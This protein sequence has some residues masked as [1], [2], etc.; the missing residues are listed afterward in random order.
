MEMKAKGGTTR[1]VMAA[2]DKGGENECRKKSRNEALLVGIALSILVLVS[3]RGVTGNDFINYD[4]PAYVTENR[5]VQRGLSVTELSWALTAS[6]AGNWHPLTWVSLMV[7]R[8]LFGMNAAGYHGTNVILHLASGLLLFVV[9]GRMTGRLWCSGL[10]SAF[11]LVHPLHVESVAWIAERKDVLSGLFWMLSIWAYV[12]YVEH[13]GYIRYGWVVLFFVLGFLSKPMVVTLP[14]VLLLL[15]WWP[16]RRTDERSILSLLGEKIPLVVLS[17]AGSIVTFFV[18]SEGGAVDSFQSLPLAGRFVNS[19][20]SYASYLVKMLFPLDLSAFY[21]RPVAWSIPE[22][23]LSLSLIFLISFFVLMRVRR[24][25]YLG[26]GWLWYLGMLVPVIGFVQV[27]AQ[28]MADRYTYLPLIGVFIMAVWGLDDLLKAIPAG[29]WVGGAAAGATLLVL[30]VMTQIQV[31]YWKDSGALFTHALRV[32]DN[33][34]VAHNNLGRASADQGNYREA[35]DQ[36][37][38]AIRISPYYMAAYNNLGI[39]LMKTGRLPEAMDSFTMALKIKPGDGYVHFNRGEVF[40]LRS[41]WDEAITEYR[42]ALQE[43]PY[44]PALRNNLGAALVKQGRLDDAVLQ[45]RTALRLDP[46]HAGAHA[47][48]GMLLMGRGQDEEAIGHFRE[49][50]RHRPEYA[51]A[52]YQLA[53]ALKKQGRT[54]ESVYH[55]REARRIK[56][57]IENAQ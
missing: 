23:L 27:G 4:D 25:P 41:M 38:E 46:E 22:V 12:R 33:N 5:H 43:K 49:A 11:F 19:A 45:F 31:G 13:P 48:L 10:V 2:F 28:A 37:G 29:R 34:F 32:T 20:V 21:P 18:Q 39:A 35:I 52:H 57:D 54:D 9:L 3:Y 53:R 30:V 40:S 17:A 36:Y 8:A 56:P 55:L 42:L 44:D 47:N 50:L 51:N 1:A 15:D 7:D 16:L 6:Y 24:Q 14:F 26:T